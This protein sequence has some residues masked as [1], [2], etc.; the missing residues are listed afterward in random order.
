M[1]WLTIVIVMAA[2]LGVLKT[3][4]YWISMQWWKQV[5]GRYLM[6]QSVSY[7]LILVF[8]AV[9]RLHWIPTS[10]NTRNIALAVYAL[11]ASVEVFG[12]YVFWRMWRLKRLETAS[13]PEAP[14]PHHEWVQS[15]RPPDED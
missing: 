3:A 15:L 1:N 9:T 11:I 7:G 13:V 14:D 6:Y 12:S 4:V 2:S 8:V 10:P 5:I